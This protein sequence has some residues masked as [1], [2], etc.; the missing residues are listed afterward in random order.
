MSVVE[1]KAEEN[2]LAQSMVTAILKVSNDSNEK[3]TGRRKVLVRI[4][5]VDV[6]RGRLCQ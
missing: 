5:G 3:R 2:C 1:V 4:Q 6:G